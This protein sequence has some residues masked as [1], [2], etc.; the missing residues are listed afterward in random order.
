M[1]TPLRCNPE[2]FERDLTSNVIIITGANSG[3]GLETSRHLCDQGATLIFACRDE[4]KA[5][6]AIKDV[7]GNGIFMCLDLAS[8]DSVR[9]FA[10]SFREK[11]DRLDVLV[12]NAGVM[13]CPEWTTKDGFEM[14]FGTNHLGHFL[15]F[16][17]LLPLLLSTAKLT[18]TPSRFIAVSSVAAAQMSMQCKGPAEIYFDDMNWKERSGPKYDTWAAYK[19]SKLANYLHAMEASTRYDKT[20]LISVS[21]HPGWVRSN[22]DQY[23]LGTGCF[24]SL[25]RRMFVWSGQMISAD[26]GAQTTLHCVLEDPS[27]LKSGSFYS[28]FG[29]YLDKDSKDGGWPMKLPNENATPETA[30][31][32]WEVSED[33]VA[34]KKL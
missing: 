13:A 6:T 23:S 32:L 5:E 28:Q 14:Q 29:I 4:K 12:N 16:K 17:E 2:L 15:L 22:L 8:L 11:Y 10:K 30:K 34:N 25:I 3:C 27:K 31:K 7:G 24:A 26:D 1:P 18:S 21:V 33:L 9:S 20:E 19:Q